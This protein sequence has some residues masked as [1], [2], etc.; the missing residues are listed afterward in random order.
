M[1]GSLMGKHAVP[2]SH[3]AGDLMARATNDVREMNLMFN[4]GLNLVVG[5][6]QLSPQYR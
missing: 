2:D 4:P 6:A 5:S 1:Y 3:P